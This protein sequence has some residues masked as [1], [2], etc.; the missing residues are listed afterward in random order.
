MSCEKKKNNKLTFTHNPFSAPKP[1]FLKNLLAK[2]KKKDILTSQYD[3]VLNGFE[4]GGGSIR[5]HKPERLEA[6]FEII[7]YKK[8]EIKEKFGH[9][10]QAFEYGAPPHGGIAYGLD[11]FVSIIQKE[12]NIRE[13]IAF[14]KTGDSRDL[15]MDSPSEVS[16]QQLKELKI[17]LD[18]KK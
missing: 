7:G 15:M 13:V 8:A 9:M 4:I 18:K 6:V 10:L 12:E 14:P 17:K 5:N 2:K 16:V 11:R 3:I 1:E